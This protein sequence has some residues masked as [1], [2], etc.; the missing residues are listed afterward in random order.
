[1]AI[2]EESGISDR[3]ELNNFKSFGK[4]SDQEGDIFKSNKDVA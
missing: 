3:N 2:I 1:M 4:E